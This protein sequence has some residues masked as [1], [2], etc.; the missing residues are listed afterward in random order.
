MTVAEILLEYPSLEAE[1]VHHCLHYA[2]HMAE[3][4]E[5]PLAVSG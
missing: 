5:V 3:H 2:A 1:D 4:R